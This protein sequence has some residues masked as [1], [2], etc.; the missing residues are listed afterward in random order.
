M[1]VMLGRAHERPA[2]FS[3]G[4]VG[5]ISFDRLRLGDVDLVKILLS[6]TKR[7]PLE[8]LS[9]DRDGAVFPQLKKR[10]FCRRAQLNIVAVRLFLKKPPERQKRIRRWAVICFHGGQFKTRHVRQKEYCDE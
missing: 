4:D 10:R 3:A 9:I 7:V 5:K 1:S 8:K 2:Q 6:K